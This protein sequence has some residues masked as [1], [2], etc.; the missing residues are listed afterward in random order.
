MFICVL[1]FMLVFQINANNLSNS[2][3]TKSIINEKDESLMLLIPEGNFL[4]GTNNVNSLDYTYNK[5]TK[6]NKYYLTHFY[7]DAY[8]IN[9]NKY[10]R[11][12]FITG[13]IQDIPSMS[14]KEKKT[15]VSNV[16]YYDARSYC[17][18]AGKRLP[19]ELEWEKVARSENPEYK[20]PIGLIFIPE[21]CNT[22]ESSLG[23]LRASFELQDG[24]LYKTNEGDQI[25]G[26]CGNVAEWT[27]SSLMPYKGNTRS[28]F[29]YGSRYKVLRG[30]SYKLPKNYARS[31][32]RMFAN[33]YKKEFG[34]RCARDF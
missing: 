28:N 19:T 30:G 26:L 12:L 29:Q 15:P 24:S 8:E 2:I 5:K 1:L 34:F 22:K 3:I 13:K 27:D 18:W 17:S 14:Y 31:Y 7:I 20:Y 6:S 9:Q 32:Y 21:R 11:Y 25:Y 4:L 23:K 33:P 10:Y 16:N